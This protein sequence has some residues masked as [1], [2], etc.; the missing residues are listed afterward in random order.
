[1]ETR[2]QGSHDGGVTGPKEAVTR[3]ISAAITEA[4]HEGGGP[5]EGQEEGRRQRNR[6]REGRTERDQQH[7]VDERQS[8]QQMVLGK[9]GLHMQ[10]NETRPPAYTTHKN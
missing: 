8:L 4:G 5:M 9:L 6:G 7:S 3:V 1:M 10:K 2:D